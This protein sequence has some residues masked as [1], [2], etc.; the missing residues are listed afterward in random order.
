MWGGGGSLGVAKIQSL[1][2]QGRWLGGTP[3][4]RGRT[5]FATTSQSASLTAPLRGEPLGAAERA[6]QYVVGDITSTTQDGEEGAERV[7]KSAESIKIG[8]I[9]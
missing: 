3:R 8:C 9:F 4:R 1:P 6:P 5:K 7:G 2:F